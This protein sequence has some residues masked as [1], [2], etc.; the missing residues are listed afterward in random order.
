MSIWILSFLLFFF[1]KARSQFIS[2]VVPGVSTVGA[3]TYLNVTCGICGSFLTS[4]T[5]LSIT[6]SPSHASY[7]YFT[8]PG[9][10]A[11]CGTVTGVTSFTNNNIRFSFVGT[12][13]CDTVEF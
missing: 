12:A 10:T 1:E 9:V 13:L 5:N 11:T 6:L 3:S 4:T 7:N 2:N 8:A